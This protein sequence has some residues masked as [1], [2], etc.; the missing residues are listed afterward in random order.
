MAKPRR[1][2]LTRGRALQHCT[3]ATSRAFSPCAHC[4]RSSLPVA[5]SATAFFRD[6]EAFSL[7]TSAACLI[8]HNRQT[9]LSSITFVS[10]SKRPIPTPNPNSEG[11]HPVAPTPS[12]SIT[13]LSSRAFDRD[14]PRFTMGDFNGFGGSDEENAEIRRL[15][16]E[17]VSSFT[18][19]KSIKWHTV[20]CA[21]FLT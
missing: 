21:R 4:S 19:P 5:F 15:N 14:H 20:L 12:F 1:A 10:I 18:T 9:I 13:V 16:S 6:E 2:V 8:A 17:I 3:A 11:D 7:Q